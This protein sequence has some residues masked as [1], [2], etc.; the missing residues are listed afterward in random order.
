M[1][2]RAPSLR[3]I[4]FSGEKRRFSY[5]EIPNEDGCYDYRED[6]PDRDANGDFGFRR[7]RARSGG[8]ADC[9]VIW[10]RRWSWSWRWRWC[11][12]GIE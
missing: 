5:P 11:L 8:L 1:H 10:S 12:R 3:G 6:Y 7:K 9:T 2:V 4:I